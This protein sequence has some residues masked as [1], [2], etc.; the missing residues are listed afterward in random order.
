[1]KQKKEDRLK[2]K[3]EKTGYVSRVLTPSKSSQ[4]SDE[5]DSIDL[6]DGKEEEEEVRKRAGT[7]YEA[8]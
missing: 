3:R 6:N 2:L 1:M 7:A 5:D 8:V 4:N